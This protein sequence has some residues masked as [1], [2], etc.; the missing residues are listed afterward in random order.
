MNTLFK[1]IPSPPTRTLLIWIRACEDPH[2]HSAARYFTQKWLAEL[3][4]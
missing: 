4:R 2:P 3:A 1:T